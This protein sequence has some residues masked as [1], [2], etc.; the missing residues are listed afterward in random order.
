[1]VEDSNYTQ[2]EESTPG[3]KLSTKESFEVEGNKVNKFHTTRIAIVNRFKDKKLREDINEN[4][5][6]LGPIKCVKEKS[7]SGKDFFNLVDA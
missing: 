1:M 3:V 7:A 4:S 6:P 2:G 5:I